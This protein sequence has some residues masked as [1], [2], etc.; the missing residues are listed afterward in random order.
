MQQQN[1]SVNSTT[2]SGEDDYETDTDTYNSDSDYFCLSV[3]SISTADENS[4]LDSD[5]E[6][7]DIPIADV[8]MTPPSYDRETVSDIDSTSSE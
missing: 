7:A 8:P 3:S 4:D 5:Y 6:I 2:S 1:S